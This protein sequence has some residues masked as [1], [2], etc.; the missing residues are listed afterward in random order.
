MFVSIRWRLASPLFFIVLIVSV[1]GAFVL[2]RNI[3]DGVQVSQENL[4]LESTRSVMDRAG[5]QYEIYFNIAQSVAF[6]VGVPDAVSSNNPQILQ[7]ILES[8]ARLDNL[9][10]IIVTNSEGLEVLGIQSV[11]TAG[12]EDYAVSTGTDLSREP[13]LRAILNETLD[14]A[15]GLMLTP[16]G[17]LVFTAVPIFQG[18][19]FG[20]AALVG[21]SLETLLL[22]LQGSAL[23]D[24]AFYG[25][26]GELLQT[27]LQLDPA[28]LTLENGVFNQALNAT[29]QI[30]LR[31]FDVETETYQGTYQ[32][33]RFGGNTLG[34][35]GVLMRDSIPY[36]TE[37]GKQ[38]TALMAAALMGFGVTAVFM[39]ASY[40]ARRAEQITDVA[41][42]LSAGK[43]TARTKMQP[44]DEISAV[45]HAL[46]QYADYVQEREDEMQRELRRQRREFTH[47]LKVVQSMPD[48]LVVQDTN[49]R[50]ILMNDPARELLGSQRVFRSAGLH[51]LTENV[52]DV[53]G[54]SLAPGLYA[55]GDP[56][57]LALDERILQAQAGAIVSSTDRR[58]GT[59]I[60]LRDI[61][62]EV[63]KERERDVMLQRLSWDVQQPLAHL[64]RLGMTSKNDMMQAFA[65]EVIK[66]AVALQKMIVD[67]R[68]LA[69]VDSSS[70]QRRQQPLALETLIWSIAN[71]WRQ[72]A[73]ASNLT[74]HVMIE[75]RGLFVLG[76]EKRLRWAIGNIV[77]N[78][79]KYTPAGGALTLEIKPDVD[80]MANFR[81]RDNGVGILK[82]ERNYIFTRFYRG[83]PTSL[84]GEVIR[85][86]GMG[87]GLFIA[88]QIVEAHAGK[89][90]LK[91]TQGVGT[92]VYISLPLTSGYELPYMETDMEG[93]TVRLPESLMAELD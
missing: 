37:T 33:F 36:V 93:E 87:Q 77:D 70:V 78:A 23:A 51:E 11:N 50:V 9:D 31:T 22:D 59:V 16:N 56:H 24:I 81:V 14:E 6:T 80:G 72:V 79:I 42:E 8:Y 86:P 26:D 88:K 85:V 47:L 39:G 30:P 40:Y 18:N 25:T 46:D 1:V 21:Q 13:I 20:G 35:V 52:P 44:S 63:R 3:A 61:T 74:M 57:H 84:E 89:I 28:W 45:G 66:Q 60:M 43:Q 5:Q 76:D 29:N 90:K 7:P 92:A 27:T 38:I 73:T 62:D 4:L 2:A 55:L 17:I 15:S 53:L 54:R 58:L 48:G 32:P 67:M 41:Q 64:G 75:K 68:E 83:T 49:G 34:V 91:S 65:R 10:S 12:V 69:V 19:A 71:E 82:D